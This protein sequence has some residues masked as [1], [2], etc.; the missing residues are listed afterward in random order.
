MSEVGVRCGKRIRC[1]D[2]GPGLC[3]KLTRS[4]HWFR[5]TCSVIL[6]PVVLWNSESTEVRG[7][8]LCFQPVRRGRPVSDGQASGY[9][10][11]GAQQRGQVRGRRTWADVLSSL[12]RRLLRWRREGEPDGRAGTGQGHRAG[13]ALGPSVPRALPA[14]HAEEGPRGSSTGGRRVLSGEVSSEART[15][16]GVGAAEH[17]EHPRVAAEGERAGSEAAAYGTVYVSS[18]VLGG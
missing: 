9:G 8:I 6:K 14:V 16:W 18:R 2:L 11:W 7:N 17:T 3:V 12:G 1:S 4:A 10:L 15:A 5:L 13:R